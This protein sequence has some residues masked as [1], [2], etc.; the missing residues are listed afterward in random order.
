MASIPG[1][2]LRSKMATLCSAIEAGTGVKPC[3][4]RA[5]RFDLSPELLQILP[6]SGINVDSSVAP[7]RRVAGGPVGHFASP[8]DPHRHPGNL[9]VL[10]VP[11]TTVPV[12]PA[13]ARAVVALAPGLPRP[14]QQ[15]LYSVTRYVNAAGM[16]PAWY[17]LSSMKLAARLHARRGG[18]TMN[19]FLHS[20]ELCPGAT[21]FHRT[22]AAV[23]GFVKKIRSFME[24]L[25]TRFPVEGRTLSGLVPMYAQ[26][27][28]GTTGVS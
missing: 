7:L 27:P 24:W 2:T 5:G 10:E 1:A 17:P 9:A 12:W 8:A 28:G 23:A 4:F 6:G 11:L 22:E 19:M 14:L 18:K 25:S 3:S 20:S 26:T 21:P 16:H 15:L 13:A